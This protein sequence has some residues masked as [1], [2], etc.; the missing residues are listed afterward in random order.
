MGLEGAGPEEVELDVK[1]KEG[2]EKEDF[3]FQAGVT[4][5][6]YQLPIVKG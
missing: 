3:R 4:R 2:R 1:R 6:S 5:S